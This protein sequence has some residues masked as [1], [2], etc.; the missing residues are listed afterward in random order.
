MTLWNLIYS[1]GPQTFINSY[2]SYFVLTSINLNATIAYE[3][4]CY[5]ID[6]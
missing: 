6:I 2:A 5:K 1:F 3:S 4:L